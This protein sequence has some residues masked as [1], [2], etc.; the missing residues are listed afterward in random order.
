[1]R[2]SDFAR[3]FTLIRDYPS[4][5]AQLLRPRRN[6]ALLVIPT[7]PIPEDR[8]YG[9]NA[10][11]FREVIERI[12][13]L[14]VGEVEILE[15]EYRGFAPHVAQTFPYEHRE[16]AYNIARRI[17]PQNLPQG[18]RQALMDTAAA[19]LLRDVMD[20]KAY[21]WVMRPWQTAVESG[22]GQALD[23]RPAGDFPDW[24]MIRPALPLEALLEILERASRR[25]KVQRDS[26]AHADTGTRRLV[27]AVFGGMKESALK[28]IQAYE[29]AETVSQAVYARLEALWQQRLRTAWDLRWPYERWDQH[30]KEP[31]SG[32]GWDMGHVGSAIDR[33]EVLDALETMPEG[34]DPLVYLLGLSA[35]RSGGRHHSSEGDTP[36][37]WE[38]VMRRHPDEERLARR[39]SLS[40]EALRAARQRYESALGRLISRGSGR[41][42]RRRAILEARYSAL[43]YL[44]SELQGSDVS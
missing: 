32:R 1:M 41:T 27:A 6:V 23:P 36:Q 22:E 30:E 26:A 5:M 42:S 28:E 10:E 21:D 4:G 14:T 2:V 16:P 35:E 9:P 31:Y 8:D 44:L 38:S 3:R 34:L 18:A 15:R 43:V 20:A 33:A 19:T 40:A 39:L 13:R 29:E 17:A 25:E 11:A 24:E 12:R 7:Y 37:D